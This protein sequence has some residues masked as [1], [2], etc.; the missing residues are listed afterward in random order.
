[1]TSNRI[2]PGARRRSV[3]RL[4]HLNNPGQIYFDL[5]ILKSNKFEQECE[6]NYRIYK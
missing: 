5:F 3:K 2:P 6:Y 1:M 4:Y